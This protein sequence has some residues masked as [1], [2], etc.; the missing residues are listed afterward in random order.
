MIVQ[1][2]ACAQHEKG[3]EQPSWH[4]KKQPVSVLKSGKSS[5]K[6]GATGGALYNEDTRLGC[7]ARGG[8]L[9]YLVW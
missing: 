6:V 4:A 3:A 1:R 8:L 9:R 5:K 7:E 2:Y